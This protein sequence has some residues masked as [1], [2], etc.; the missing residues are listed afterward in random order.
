MRLSKL[1]FVPPFGG[2]RGN[3]HG[4][5]MARWKARDGVVDFLLALIELNVFRQLSRLRRCE[6]ILVE[7]A[8]FE[9]GWVTLSANFRGKGGHPPT[10]FGVR[11]LDSLGYHVVLFA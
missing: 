10:N 3:V 1:R 2:L 8:L 4:S 7:I 5:S 9:R 6:Q 11:K